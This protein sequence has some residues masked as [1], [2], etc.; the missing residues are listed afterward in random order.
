VAICVLLSDDVA[1]GAVG[2]P[3]KL[4]EASGAAANIVI[5]WAVVRS[6]GC[7]LPPVLLPLS[8]LAFI[9]A[10]YV[11]VTPLLLRPIV[12]VVVIVPPE[13]GD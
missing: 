6:N 7:A 4:G 5:T 2:V 9:W 1:V 12:P 13:R 3:V 10:R 8:V 11:L